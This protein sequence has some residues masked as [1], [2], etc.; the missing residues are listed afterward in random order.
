MPEYLT[1]IKFR[2]E[3]IHID[4]MISECKRLRDQ[5]IIS[6]LWVSGCRPSEMLEFCK[7][8]IFFLEDKVHFKLVTKKLGRGG[9]FKVNERTLVFNSDNRWIQII[10]EYSELMSNPEVPLFKISDRAIE[11]IITKVSTTV[12]GF[13]LAPYHFRHSRMSKLAETKGLTQLMYFKG[14]ADARSVS[15]YLHGRPFEVDL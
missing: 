14:S 2:V 10:K 8:D 11:Y 4:E 3:D 5:A 12:L 7:K 1:D 9:R 6:F 15:A 13:P